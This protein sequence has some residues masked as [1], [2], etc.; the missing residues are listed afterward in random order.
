MSTDETNKPK[1]KQ[2]FAV[3]DPETRRQIAKLGG[4]ASHASGNAHQYTPEEA[5]AAGRKSHRTGNTRKR[6][7][8]GGK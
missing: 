2:G 4:R 3:M 6:A 7:D 8:P 1:A 5:R